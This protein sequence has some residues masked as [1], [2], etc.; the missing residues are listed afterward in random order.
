MI[1]N[2]LIYLLVVIL[3]ITTGSIPEK[4]QLP[5]PMALSL[6]LAKGVFFAQLARFFFRSDKIARSADYFAVEQR[7]SIVAIVF[8]SVD[9]YLLEGQYYLS[10]LPFAQALPVL[11]HLAGLLLFLGYLGILWLAARHSY[12]E[13]FTRK[14][15]TSSFLS[16]NLKINFAIVLPWLLISLL[17]DL[18]KLS[19]LPT[20]KRFLASPWGEPLLLLLFFLTLAFFLPTAVVRLWNCTPLPP[21]PT[22]E[23]IEEFCRGQRLRYADIMLWPL[24]EG[25]MLTAGVM[26]LS[27]HFRYLLVTPAL[28][29]AMTPEE[30][31]AVMAHEIGHVKRFHLQLYLLLFLGFGILAQLSSAPL[32]LLLLSSDFFYR[33]VTITGKGPDKILTLASTVV[34]LGL[35]LIYFRYLFG[36]FMRNFERQADLFALRAMGEASPL[37]RVFEKIAW[38]SGKI[39]DLPSW[40]H[41]G[42]GERIDFLRRCELEPPCADRHHRKVYLALFLYLCSLAGGAFALARMP[43]DFLGDTPKSKFVEA[44]I[45]QKMREEPDNAV[46]HQLLGDL[47]YS[48]LR[49]A[50]AIDAYNRALVLAPDNVEA[51]NNMAWLLLTVEKTELRNPARALVLAKQASILLKSPHVLDTLATA[52]W[53]NGLPELAIAVEKEALARA[54]DNQ[55]FY[56]D[57]LERFRTTTYSL[58]A[59][60]PLPAAGH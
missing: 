53:A 40:H 32:V 19:P 3:V 39:R 36:F 37:I 35:M 58:Q 2:N 38:L 55:E 15:S 10:K 22:R 54:A 25:R 33:L 26:G 47:R 8:F 7:L 44:L 34:L 50:E 42:I 30:I 49:Y 41:F 4:P 31:E 20:A 51:L 46:W 14:V 17:F 13:I 28:L 56:R 29:E 21:G 43:D 52:Y 5:W 23:R 16:A 48:L 12:Q 9:I 6:F 18:I 57:Q 59:P 11:A 27:R 24:F 1:Y 45:E 60:F